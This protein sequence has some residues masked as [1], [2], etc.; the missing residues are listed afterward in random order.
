M[1]D[2]GD[3]IESSLRKADLETLVSKKLPTL[4]VSD[5]V[6]SQADVSSIV[7]T[8]INTILPDTFFGVAFSAKEIMEAA[9]ARAMI[10]IGSAIG[11]N[12]TTGTTTGTVTNTQ[13]AA[14]W[15][16]SILMP[17]YTSSQGEIIGFG[18][19]TPGYT[20]RNAI[21]KFDLKTIAAMAINEGVSSD[22]LFDMF[23]DKS[24]Y[25]SLA[26]FQQAMLNL[27]IP[28]FASG[29]NNVP[30]D[31]LA[32]IHKDEAIIPAPFNPERYSKASGNTALVE[33][34][35]ALRA[36]VSRLREEQRAGNNA[37]AAN[38]RKTA[39]A[40]TKFDTDGMPETRT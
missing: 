33:E 5:F 20:L 15:A 1:V 16:K 31:M 36:E 24:K 12:T 39:Q 2:V 34:I 10:G 19:T 26:D 6:S 17:T 25:G 38:T 37:I 23:P 30:H 3:L 11:T 7:G 28:A 27:G 4:S 18:Y 29:T 21:G 14:D 35:K 13:S 9:I 8:R 22:K 32:M 40:L